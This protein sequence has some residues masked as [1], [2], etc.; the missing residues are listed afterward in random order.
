LPGR[1]QKLG[2]I[3]SVG[4]CK[5]VAG[6][7][8]SSAS[9]RRR[10]QSRAA[11]QLWPVVGERARMRRTMAARGL[12]GLEVTA[13]IPCPNGSSSA[14]PKAVLKSGSRWGRAGRPRAHAR[15]SAPRSKPNGQMGLRALWARL[16]GSP[17]DE[18]AFL[19]AA[20]TATTTTAPLSSRPDS[21]RLIPVR[22]ARPGQSSQ[23]RL[24]ACNTLC[25]CASSNN[26]PRDQRKHCRPATGSESG[27]Q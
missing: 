27:E 26:A 8:L 12:A 19:A 2:G 7:I 23:R 22:P 3:L 15:R 21:T 5:C 24:L 9:R 17:R 16:A 4:R 20:A 13:E 14:R 1:Q 10:T 11:R 25:S 6:P 18:R